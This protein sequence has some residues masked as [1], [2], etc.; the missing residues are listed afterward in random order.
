MRGWKFSLIAAVSILI[1]FGSAAHP[2]F[3]SHG[4]VDPD[5]ASHDPTDFIRREE[6]IPMRDGVKLFTIIL[7]PRTNALMPILLTRTPY[8]ALRRVPPEQIALPAGDDILMGTEYIRVFQDVRGKYRSEGDY[9]MNRPLRGPL[10]PTEVDHSTDAYDT[11]EWLV[12][13]VSE[14]NGRVGI[15]GASYDGFLALMAIVN[16]HPAL[17]VAIAINPMVDGWI[18]DDWFHR[19]AF[20][21]AMIDYIKDQDATGSSTADA[22]NAGSDEYALF[23]NAGSAGEMG[24]L[25]GLASLEFWQNLLR[26]PS[27]DDFWQ[28]QAV[29]KI[30]A[31]QP[32]KVPTMFVHSLWDQEDIYGAIAAYRAIEPLD[33]NNDKNYL[34]I[35]PWQHSGTTRDEE[36]LGPFRFDG[37]TALYF[38]RTILLPFLDERLKEGAPKAGTPPV[39]AYATGTNTWQRYDAWP[40]SCESGCSHKMRPLY[41]KPEL[42]LGFEFANP[43]GVSFVEY[44]SD[45]AMPV[46]YRERPISPI[47]SQGSTWGRWLADDQRSFSSRPDVVTYKSDILKQ[48]VALGG[49]P[50]AN[51]FVSTSGT[52]CDLIVKLI[53]IYP[54]GYPVQP[55]LAGYQLMVSSD[56]LRGRY[57]N[58]PAHPSAV[59][60]GK[61]ERYRWPLPATTHAFLPGHRIMV[62]IQSSWFPLYDRNPQSFVENIFFAKPEDY[63]KAAIRIYQSGASPSFIELPVIQ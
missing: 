3:L 54:D 10:N 49:Q 42:R 48:P 9:V 35:G 51:L 45:P 32:L 25:N 43:T 33:V 22:R 59:P 55:E 23:L 46:P 11:I 1:L 34:V 20:R 5:F 8:A 16:P 50:I 39:L 63:R 19:G 12:K 57:R 44:I 15:T 52:D 24:R 28:I 41:L 40:R 56:V 38:R 13:N 62:Q 37:N 21:Q 26:H 30:L 53:D 7:V 58:D 29:D 60:A 6:M 27:Y 14:N 36:S 2:Q 61:I 4:L 18:G 17:K 47:Y 31:G